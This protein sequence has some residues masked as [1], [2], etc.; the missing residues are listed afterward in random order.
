MMTVPTP[1][2]HTWQQEVRALRPL[3]C[4]A[5][6]RPHP[7]GGP[8]L[9]RRLQLGGGRIFWVVGAPAAALLLLLAAVLLGPAC[10]GGTGAQLP[11]RGLDQRPGCQLV[12]DLQQLC[13]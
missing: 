1:K 12:D 9:R 7:E 5:E 11:G 4:D 10:S 3:G 8:H 13:M 2:P 6:L